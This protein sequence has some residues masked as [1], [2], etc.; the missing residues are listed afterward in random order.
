MKEGVYTLFVHQFN[1]R[2]GAQGFEA[3]IDFLGDVTK[4]AYP[5]AMRDSERVEIA[6][7]KY[8]K[9]GGIE[10][11]SSL[12]ST[13][14]SKTVWGVPTEDFVKVSMVML[15]PNHWNGHGVGNKH[16]FFALD[17]CVNDG[18]ARGFYNEFLDERLNPHRKVFE[19]VA[20]RAKPA[21]SQE[22]LSGL[23]FSSTQRNTL[24]CRV[25]GNF[26]RVIRIVF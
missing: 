14:A 25:K 9:K 26:S 20:S 5:K 18:T 21:P 8:T 4:F 7:F 11:I 2:S 24:Y 19:L 6:K 15:S 23:G 1:R 13:T 17:K 3:E 12:P 16:Y 10:F 22:Q